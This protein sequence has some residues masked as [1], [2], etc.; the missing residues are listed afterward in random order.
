MKL[1]DR[2]LVNLG[3]TFEGDSLGHISLYQKPNGNLYYVYFIEARYFGMK[4]IDTT[5]DSI[6]EQDRTSPDYH[7]SLDIFFEDKTRYLGWD[8]MFGADFMDEN[9][10]PLLMA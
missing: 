4:E 7:Y 5:T 8:R 6:V 1:L 3:R 10:T 9:Y 2:T